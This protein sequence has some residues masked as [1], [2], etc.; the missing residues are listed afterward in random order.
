MHIWGYHYIR[1]GIKLQSIMYHICHMILRVYSCV[2][3][4]NTKCTFLERDN[5]L[6]K[7]RALKKSVILYAHKTYFLFKYFAFFSYYSW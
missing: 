2:Y 3:Y 5:I 6:K 1:G 7:Q 4:H